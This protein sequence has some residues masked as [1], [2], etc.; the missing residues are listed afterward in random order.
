MVKV[1]IKI[2]KPGSLGI[3]FDDSF[4]MNKRK[5]VI[6]AKK[7]GEKKVISKLTALVTFNKPSR[8]LTMIQRR[9]RQR[10]RSQSQRLIRFIA[11]SFVRKKRVRTGTGLGR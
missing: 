5:L 8:G 11:S 4:E 3:S 6:L 7:I 9:S 2:K 1:R 10:V